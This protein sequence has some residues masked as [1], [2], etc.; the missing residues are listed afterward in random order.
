MFISCNIC[1]LSF[2]L[3]VNILIKQ[4]SDSAVSITHWLSFKHLFTYMQVLDCDDM[5]FIR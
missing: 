3:Q 5:F 1:I 2:V 4:M